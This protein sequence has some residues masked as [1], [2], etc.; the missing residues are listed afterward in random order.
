MRSASFRI[1]I[2]MMCVGW[3]TVGL[4]Y[5]IG[6]LTP[7]AVHV[8]QETALDRLIPFNVSA[9]GLYLSFFLLVPVAYLFAAPARLKSLMFAMQLSAVLAAIVFVLYPTTL[10]YPVASSST[11][12][13]AVLNMLAGFDSSNNCLP[14]LHG[15]L[16]LLCVVALWQREKMWRNIF[17]LLWALGIAWAV[18]QTRRHLVLDLGAGLLLGAGCAWLAAR[19][20]KPENIMTFFRKL[21]CTS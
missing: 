12:G 2:A 5:A 4:C 6:S 10:I 17:M 7:R 3:G 11:P 21:K 9:I 8:L 13:G 19:V 18:V 14:S 15:A 1:R 16:T 20:S